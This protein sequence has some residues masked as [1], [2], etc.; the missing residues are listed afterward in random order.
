MLVLNYHRSVDFWCIH[1]SRHL[2]MPCTLSRT[3]SCINNYRTTCYVVNDWFL[4]LALFFGWGGHFP[5]L[6]EMSK[7][8]WSMLIVD[9]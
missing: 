5:R 8:L 9:A 6:E 7:W 2:L 3:L 1:I 4:S